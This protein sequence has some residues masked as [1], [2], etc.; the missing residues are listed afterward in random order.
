MPL[1]WIVPAR[2]AVVC[3][4][5]ENGGSETSAIDGGTSE[6]VTYEQALNA[7]IASLREN[8]DTLKDWYLPSRNPADQ[9][10][11]FGRAHAA[12]TH[13]TETFL[14]S[15]G[16]DIRRITI[17]YQGAHSVALGHLQTISSPTPRFPVRLWK[18][19]FRVLNE[20]QP[21]HHADGC[22]ETTVRRPSATLILNPFKE[23]SNPQAIFLPGD[24]IEFPLFRFW[25]AAGLRQY[26]AAV[27]N[28]KGSFFLGTSVGEIVGPAGASATSEAP[29]PES[30]TSDED[31][32]ALDPGVDD[33][34][35]AEPD[36]A[37]TR[38]G[39]IT[40]AG[41]RIRS[42][43][44]IRLHDNIL[45]MRFQLLLNAAI[46]AYYKSSRVFAGTVTG[47]EHHIRQVAGGEVHGRGLVYGGV[48]G[49]VNRSTAPNAYIL[50]S[51]N[52]GT[53]ALPAS[54]S[55]L[56]GSQRLTWSW[57]CSPCALALS[58]YLVNTSS[59]FPSDGGHEIYTEMHSPSTPLGDFADFTEFLPL[60]VNE[61]DTLRDTRDTTVQA[62]L[63]QP[64]GNLVQL[65]PR[66]TSDRAQPRE[67]A[68]AQM[69]SFIGE[70]WMNLSIARHEYSIVRLWPHR[71]ILNSGS[72]GMPPLAG[73]I[74][75][76]NPIDGTSYN[77]DEDEGHLYI[78]EAQGHRA[79]TSSLSGAYSCVAFDI[80]PFRWKKIDGFVIGRKGPAD[81]TDRNTFYLGEGNH[82]RGDM[83]LVGLTRF[84]NDTVRAAHGDLRAYRPISF[85]TTPAILE[86]TLN[87][88]YPDRAVPYPTMAE[89]DNH[90]IVNADGD[91]IYIYNS[92]SFAGSNR[93][94]MHTRLGTL[95]E[96]GNLSN[97]G[98]RAV[99]AA[100]GER[101]FNEHVAGAQGRLDSQ[102]EFC[103]RR[104]ASRGG[105]V[106]IPAVI[107][108]RI[109]LTE[110]RLQHFRSLYRRNNEIWYRLHHGVATDGDRQALREALDSRARR[111]GLEDQDYDSL[112]GRPRRRIQIFRQTMVDP[113]RSA[114]DSHQQA[115]H[116]LYA[117]IPGPSIAERRDWQE[118]L[119]RARV[120]RDSFRGLSRAD[121]ERQAFSDVVEIIN[122]VRGMLATT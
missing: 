111:E 9:Q 93:D 81:R 30:D 3:K 25:S 105:E 71:K 91:S 31:H 2:R 110:S 21:T 55:R 42:P 99:R 62:M 109:S 26:R 103:R 119:R 101:K 120:R 60:R 29:E 19:P 97:Q 13:W 57:S 43:G 11:L 86:E 68:V 121:R 14:G 44:Q 69:R 51:N 96:G 78:F 107:Q 72:P 40:A 115:L 80:Y 5:P 77:D 45:A 17:P 48:L 66:L 113:M 85:Y 79:P 24:V 37:A 61:D 89:A 73:W 49:C 92:I 82:V 47:L 20:S 70:G 4:P 59:G 16:A 88:Y 36:P 56:Q 58:Y 75:A 118:R 10:N 94:A 83:F 63:G 8:G 98:V 6:T 39:D 33:A 23:V 108:A 102:V 28:P 35:P 122:R 112:S 32:E 95:V 104:L 100:L 52:W 27:F 18:G 50:S 106:T 114:A 116:D 22:V 46:G 76:Y 84:N 34:S 41:W 65:I 74:G 54:L 64:D 53:R 87:A 117:L 12:L 38:E 67:L 15:D 7:W 90:H 1:N